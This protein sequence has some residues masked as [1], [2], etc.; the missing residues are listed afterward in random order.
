MGVSVTGYYILSIQSASA[1]RVLYTDASYEP[2][3]NLRSC[4]RLFLNVPLSNL[5]TR[6]SGPVLFGPLGCGQT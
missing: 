2:A 6:D 5:T 4:S 1:K 3:C